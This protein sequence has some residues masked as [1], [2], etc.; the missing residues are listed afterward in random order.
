MDYGDYLKLDA[1][2]SAQAPLSDEHDELL[3]IVIH[4][5]TE[6]WLKLALHE[7]RECRK[8]IDAA[9]SEKA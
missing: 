4:Q 2:L 5:A 1:L 8:L 7:L 6:L 9:I 3:F